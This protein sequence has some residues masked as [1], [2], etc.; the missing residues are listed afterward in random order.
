M[1]TV[2][3]NHA[4]AMIELPAATVVQNWLASIS[5]MTAVA[6][7]SNDT[8][9]RIGE[10]WHG[11]GG[12]YAG[13]MRGE[14]GMPDRHLIVPTDTAAEFASVEWGKHGTEITSCEWTRYGMRNTAAMESAGLELAKKI[15]ALQF[16]G[17]SDFYLP[18][19]HELRLCWLNV[20]ELFSKAWYWSSTQYSA[21]YAFSQLFDCGDQVNTDKTNE[22]RARA[23]R[24]IQVSN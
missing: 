18:A 20:P 2:R 15:R 23:V 14:E 6:A 22:L 21:H 5:G 8:P 19:R 7:A 3:L 17:H 11:Q 16:E 13:I 10:Y 24:S 12:I 1:Q 9:P 4:G